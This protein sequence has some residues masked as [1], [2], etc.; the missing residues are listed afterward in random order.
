[1]TGARVRCKP[2]NPPAAPQARP[3]WQD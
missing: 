1:V 2:D 3:S